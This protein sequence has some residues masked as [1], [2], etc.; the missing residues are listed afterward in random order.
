MKEYAASTLIPLAILAGCGGGGGEESTSGPVYSVAAP[1]SAFFAKQANFNLSAKDETGDLY[2]LS[3]YQ[4]PGPDIYLDDSDTGKPL[5]QLHTLLVVYPASDPYKDAYYSSVNFYYSTDPFMIW[6]VNALDFGRPMYEQ[7][8]APSF[9]RVN[10]T[11]P[12][13]S[14]GPLSEPEFLNGVSSRSFT[15]SLKGETATTAWLCLNMTTT[16]VEKGSSTCIRVDE[17]G[18]PSGFKAKAP[19]SGRGTMLE[20]Q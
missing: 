14:M 8:P 10:S 11:G 1:L 9:A 2:F 12:L 6:G 7:H 4:G 16:P 19:V 17:S 5:K 13:S 20:F 3:Y 18:A 15:W